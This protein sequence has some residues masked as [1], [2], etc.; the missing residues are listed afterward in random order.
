MSSAVSTAPPNDQPGFG[1]TAFDARAGEGC[2]FSFA[3]CIRGSGPH[4][5]ARLI[6]RPT[7]LGR[8][9]VR[10]G[11]M[12]D[13]RPAATQRAEARVEQ[14]AGLL[15]RVRGTDDDGDQGVA[16]AARRGDERVAAAPRVTGL[17]ADRTGVT[18]QEPVVVDHA[19]LTTVTAR[20]LVVG[21]QHHRREVRLAEE[22]TR[23]DGQVAGTD[24][25]AAAHR[26]LV[27]EPGRIAQDGRVLQVQGACLG[28]KEAL[29]AAGRPAAGPLGHGDGCVVRRRQ[30][31]RVQETV[32]RPA[33]S[34]LRGQLE[35]RHAGGALRDRH[36]IGGLDPL[37]HDE[38]GEDLDRACHA[39]RCP[40]VGGFD[41]GSGRRIHDDAGFRR[42]ERRRRVRR[43]RRVPCGLRG[44]TTGRRERGHDRENDQRR[45]GRDPKP[46]T[47]T[48]TVKQRSSQTRFRG[49]RV[50]TR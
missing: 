11:Q 46:R 5:R 48:K 24:Q 22:R 47:R 19:V 49:G 34:G 17:E 12:A 45:S 3:G 7:R 25:V 33:L 42:G 39:D 2:A 27:V 6:G 50:R 32:S 40:I 18:A 44:R 20:E 26:E 37:V 38:R 30:E 41:D 43:R 4:L 16:V 14:R 10:R 8:L 29:V 9:L 21:Q 31:Q 36:T 1:G 15:H 23:H 35:G 28:A 13:R